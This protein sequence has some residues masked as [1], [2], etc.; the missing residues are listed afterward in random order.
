MIDLTPVQVRKLE[1][2]R[3]E[4]SRLVSLYEKPLA[5]VE[6]AFQAMQAVFA[7]ILEAHGQEANGET[8]DIR[9][10]GDAVRLVKRGASDS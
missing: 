6:Q 9:E 4:Y 7:S 1:Q 5:E 2:S 3:A 10:E 8:W